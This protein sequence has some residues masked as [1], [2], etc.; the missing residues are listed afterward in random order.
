MDRLDEMARVV[1]DLASEIESLRAANTGTQA[2]L[3]AVESQLVE[4]LAAQADL[5]G[6]LE[7][8]RLDRTR[9]ATLERS[10]EHLAGDRQQYVDQLAADLRRAI[11]EGLRR[12]SAQTQQAS[13]ALARL[14]SRVEEVESKLD[15]GAFADQLNLLGQRLDVLAARLE[16]VAG[17]RED[18]EEA[19][20]Q[21]EVRTEARFA[22]IQRRL[23]AQEQSVASWQSRIENQAQTVLHSQTLAQA[24]VEEGQ[25]LQHTQHE[26]A[27]AQRVWQQQLANS[28]TERL[29]AW[30]ANWQ[31]FLA[32]RT[33]ERRL[34]DG[35]RST[36]EAALRAV[37]ER[38]AELEK[39][40]EG[41]AQAARQQSEAHAAALQA[42]GQ[43][44]LRFVSAVRDQLST[45]LS[46]WQAAEPAE[47]RP[48][49]NNRPTAPPRG[50][51]AERGAPEE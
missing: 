36:A 19:A 14:T 27:E 29:A 41:Q 22:E 46:R 39:K 13:Q 10:L 44:W 12:L 11:E 35:Q 9:L 1:R 32:Q 7:Q 47:E 4:A 17:T 45:A 28:L 15:A 49:A 21:R 16:E 18:I 30:E 33:Q 40:L 50:P 24:M 26:L 2:R 5:A 42:T 8:L 3:A 20:R 6:Q 31:A 25:R 51:H 34:R 43:E 48:A 37:E 23:G 38:L